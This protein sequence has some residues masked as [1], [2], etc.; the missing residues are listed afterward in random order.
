[1]SPFRGISEDQLPILR[2]L[3]KYLVGPTWRFLNM[4]EFDSSV[5]LEIPFGG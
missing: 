4:L 3:K 1:L 2:I 5:I